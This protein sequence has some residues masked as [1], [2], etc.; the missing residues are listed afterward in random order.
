MTKTKIKSPEKIR[1]FYIV[2]ENETM[3]LQ[4]FPFFFFLL[5][6]GSSFSYG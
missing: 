3:L 5:Q 1:G 6:K 4:I 2:I